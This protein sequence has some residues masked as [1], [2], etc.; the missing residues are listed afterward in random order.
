MKPKSNSVYLDYMLQAFSDVTG[1]VCDQTFDSFRANKLV[2]YATIRALLIVGEASKSI[3]ST[4]RDRF[5]E[6][7]WRL[8]SGM[9]DRLVHDYFDTKWQIV[10]NVATVEIPNTAESLKRV[11]D[12]LEAEEAQQH[13]GKPE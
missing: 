3:D 12:Q 10:W 5:P 7:P 4:I 2:N 8:M 13:T 11:R 1:F 9:R 6:I